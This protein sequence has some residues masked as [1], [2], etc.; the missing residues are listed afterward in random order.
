MHERSLGSKAISAGRDPE[1]FVAPRADAK[2]ADPASVMKRGRWRD[3]AGGLSFFHPYHRS[4]PARFHPRA[5]NGAAGGGLSKV[6]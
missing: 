3:D 4:P 6:L 2:G 5:C 1:G